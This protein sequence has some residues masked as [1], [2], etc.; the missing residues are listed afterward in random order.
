MTVD[1]K[2]DLARAIGGAYPR[3]LDPHP[4]AAESDL[5]GLV[6]VAHGPPLWVVAALGADDLGDLL[7]HQLGQD[8]QAEAD[9]QGQKALLRDAHQFPERLLDAWRQRALPARD[10]LLGRY[11]FLHGGPPSISAD[12]PERCQRQRTEREDRRP[13]VLRATGQPRRGMG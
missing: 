9:R 3:A 4:A 6:A 7:F 11:G 2:A 1:G 13:Q 5:T 10:G 8:A 12:R